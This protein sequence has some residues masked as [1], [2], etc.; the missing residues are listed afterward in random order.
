MKLLAFLLPAALCLSGAASAQKVT[1][2]YDR[3]ADFSRY[4]TYRWVQVPG[5]Q[6]PNQLL[7]QQIRRVVDEE[8]AQ[9][10]LVQSDASPDL[11]IAYQVSVRPQQEIQTWGDAYPWG[12]GPGMTQTTVST[13]E[14]GTLVL[15]MYDP[16]L[17]QLVWRGS[18]T[19]TID[20]SSDPDKNYRNLQ[21]TVDKLLKHYPP[22]E[23]KK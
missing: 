4:R 3:G 16:A 6:A 7:D 14:V 1:Y 10:G 20:P 17:R 13:V 2:N 5:T 12:W 9:K 18:A 19:K 8:L 21:K 23:K 11:L 15:D 22:E